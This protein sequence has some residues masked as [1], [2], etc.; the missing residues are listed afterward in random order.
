[1]FLNFQLIFICR[2]KVIVAVIGMDPE[3]SLTMNEKK[4]MK[5]KVADE[6]SQVSMAFYGPAASRA[7]SMYRVGMVSFILFCG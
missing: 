6:H 2:W 3:L 4:M 1:M 7:Y 5:I